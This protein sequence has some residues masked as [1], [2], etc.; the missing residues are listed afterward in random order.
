MVWWVVV[1]WGGGRR[2]QGSEIFPFQGQKPFVT[3]VWQTPYNIAF[4]LN[5]LIYNFVSYSLN[6]ICNV[7]QL[8]F[9]AS[10]DIHHA[11][12][13]YQELVSCCTL[14]S[15]SIKRE[16]RDFEGQSTGDP[17]PTEAWLVRTFEIPE[18]I[19]VLIGIQKSLCTFKYLIVN[20]I[21]ILIGDQHLQSTY[22]M[23]I[24][25]GS[26]VR[27]TQEVLSRK[28]LADRSSFSPIYSLIPYIQNRMSRRIPQYAHR[29]YG[30][31]GSNLLTDKKRTHIES[32]FPNPFERRSE[33]T[34]Y[35]TLPFLIGS[36]TVID[37]LP[38]TNDFMM[39]KTGSGGIKN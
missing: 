13:T 35:I 12:C 11:I 37:K 1:V 36:D 33:A 28:Q 27:S 30:V 16:F 8:D 5:C 23:G 18:G 7:T 14:G 31:Q 26:H 15:C 2:V 25:R 34:C 38:D 6:I 20:H 3:V 32:P 19:M 24:S 29:S 21:N 4:Y 39:M 22:W 9:N 17:L 10:R